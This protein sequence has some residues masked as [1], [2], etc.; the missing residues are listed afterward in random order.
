[1][2]GVQPFTA[3][4]G[5]VWHGARETLQ[6][7][8]SRSMALGFCLATI[9][10][11][12]DDR[13]MIAGRIAAGLNLTE[14]LDTIERTICRAQRLID[15]MSRHISQISLPDYSLLAEVPAEL[16]ELRTWLTIARQTSHASA[17]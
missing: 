14:R 6:P 16:A 11:H 4:F 17:A 15:D 13:D 7:D 2:T 1:M 12:F 9:E 8:G 3:R 10:R 5:Q